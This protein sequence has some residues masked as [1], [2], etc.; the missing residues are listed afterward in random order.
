MTHGHRVHDSG[1]NGNYRIVFWGH[2]GITEKR[3]ETSI[4]EVCGGSVTNLP[5]PRNYWIREVVR[6]DSRV[7][8]DKGSP[9]QE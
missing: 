5:K 9:E 2:V 8:F 7:D 4:H 6:R 3:M 1:K